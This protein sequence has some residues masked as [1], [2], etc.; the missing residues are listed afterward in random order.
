MRSLL[1]LLLVISLFL[2]ACDPT[3]QQPATKDHPTLLEQVRKLVKTHSIYDVSD[4]ELTVGALKGMVQAQNDPYSQYFTKEEAV[5]QKSRLAKERIGLGIHIIHQGKRFMIAEVVAG[6]SAAQ[7]NLQVGDTILAVDGQSV[8]ALSAEQLVEQLTGAEGS[9]ISLKIL[10]A[11]DQQIVDVEL[12]RK[13]IPQV[14]V[15]SEVIKKE[16]ENFGYIAIRVFGEDT[17]NEWKKHL[18]LL[19]TKQIQGLIVDVRGNP[20]GY[21]G[22][23]V[24]IIEDVVPKQTP[25]VWMENA[26]GELE[27]IESEANPSYTDPLIILQDS[28]SASASEVLLAALLD[29]SRAISI[30]KTSFGKGTVQET[31]D[32]NNGSSLKLSTK[33]WLTPQKKWIHGTGISPTIETKQPMV[34]EISQVPETEEDWQLLFEVLHTLGYEQPVAER[35]Q[36]FQKAN[37]L[38]ETGQVDASLLM[39]VR[40]AYESYTKNPENDEAVRLALDYFSHSQ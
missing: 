34:S 13:A 27:W 16:E 29:T 8:S 28:H 37:H 7:A 25:I 31:F 20:G 11:T 4:K 2:T 23:V 32:F 26:S 1:S 12:E 5:L 40:D 39:L 9:K 38:S 33:K 17:A 6:T 21:L 18:K 36:A 15:E 19:Q 24:P 30:G 10:K 35:I 22:S 14:T 3:N